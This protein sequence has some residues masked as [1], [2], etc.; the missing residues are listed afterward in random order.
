MSRTR[1]RIAGTLAITLAG[2]WIYSEQLGFYFTDVDTFPLISTGRVSDSAEL[3]N[4]LS[5]PLMQGLM[6][7]ALFFRPLSSLSWGLDW[8]LWGLEPFG[9]HLT[10]L[11]LHL[12]NSL[13]VYRLFL[14]LP[15]ASPNSPPIRRGDWEATLAGFFFAIHPLTMETV[16]ALARRP[17]LLFALFALLTL[18]ATHRAVTHNSK[19]ALLAGGLTA[20]LGFASKDS[21]VV[22]PAMATSMVWCF[23]SPAPVRTRLVRCAR[24]TWPP[25]LAIAVVLAWRSNILGGMGGY[26]HA[27]HAGF[28]ET[29]AL[30]L[31]VSICTALWP[32]RF[33]R[34][35]TTSQ[36]V[37]FTVAVAWLLSCAW[38][39]HRIRSDRDGAR[40][41]LYFSGLA[42]GAL[43]FV[44]VATR[45]VAL[46]RTL[47]TAS[48]FLSQIVAWSILSA[49]STLFLRWRSPQRTGPP[50]PAEHG[51]DW[52]SAAVAGV[53][54]IGVSVSIIEGAWSGRS[55]AEWRH[56]GEVARRTLEQTR[57]SARE[58]PEGSR[59]YLV[60]FPFWVAER[61]QH[62]RE[63]PIFLEHSIQGW[64]DLALP[65]LDL[66]VVGLT[67]LVGS[68]RDP[69]V[70]ASRVRFDPDDARLT[71]DVDRRAYP[72]PSPWNQTYRKQGPGRDAEFWQKGSRQG[73]VVE[74]PRNPGDSK[75][76]FFL[77]YLGDSV[78]LKPDSAWIIDSPGTLAENRRPRT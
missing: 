78:A 54:S 27:S 5:S 20:A 31:D 45:T 23:S 34:C 12:V 14:A 51:L 58:L 42:L 56:A 72:T 16:P 77:V 2:A 49:G 19:I 64:V 43:G 11:L 50:R 70:L 39:A 44:Y 10:N 21:A 24:W 63:R 9:F 61:R 65:E 67:Y 25:A 1:F 40:A 59:V 18:H 73:M 60:N 37:I 32:G 15:P 4:V 57:E 53:I 22:I 75:R 71:I 3:V 29:A 68:V 7:N 76:N 30:S 52:L 36:A 55:L 33:D 8:Y 62:L 41:R 35:A 38:L 28:L 74:I 48:I 66:E 69:A 26:V 17:D 46:P 47:Y 13:L 6:P